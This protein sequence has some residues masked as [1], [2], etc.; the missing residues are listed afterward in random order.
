MLENDIATPETI[1]AVLS[2][3]LARRWRSIGFF[4]AIALGGVDTWKQ[5]AA[6][7][8]PTLSSKNRIEGL[9]RWTQDKRDLN[10]IAAGRD[11]ALAS[12]LIRARCGD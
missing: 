6:N 11:R 10:A 4:D 5:M 3:G 12:D 2:D 9:E 8:L 7:V 1:D